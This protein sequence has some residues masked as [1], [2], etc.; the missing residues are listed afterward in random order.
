MRRLVVDRC[1]GRCV[2]RPTIP[3]AT[4]YSEDNGIAVPEKSVL[5][6]KVLLRQRRD[7]HQVGGSKGHVQ[8]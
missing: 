2:Y 8:A 1:C 7:G 6:D 3:L 4:E 5:V